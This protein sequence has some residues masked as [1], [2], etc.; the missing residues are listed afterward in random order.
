LGFRHAI[1]SDQTAQALCRSTAIHRIVAER[2]N[3]DCTIDGQPF[4]DSEVLLSACAS[5][6]SASPP[7]EGTLAPFFGRI[8]FAFDV[9]DACARVSLGPGGDSCKRLAGFLCEYLGVRAARQ[10]HRNGVFHLPAQGE[11]AERS[12]AAALRC[13]TQETVSEVRILPLSANKPIWFAVFPILTSPLARQYS[14]RFS[15]CTPPL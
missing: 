6:T 9:H 2:H 11:V 15:C 4:V 8:C 13:G 12:K 14:P 10:N 3:G 1:Y 5:E 7:G